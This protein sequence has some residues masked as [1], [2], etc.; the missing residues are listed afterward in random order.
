MFTRVTGRSGPHGILSGSWRHGPATSILLLASVVAAAALAVALPHTNVTANA[1]SASLVSNCLAE[2]STL[3]ESGELL[4]T[5]DVEG[6]RLDLHSPVDS[7]GEVRLNGLHVE[8]LGLLGRLVQAEGK[9]EVTFVA[10]RQVGKDEVSSLSWSVEVGHARCRDTSQDGGI[11]GSSILDA[12]VSH[13]ASLLQTG[14]EEEIGVVVEGNVL[15]L[16][17]GGTLN[18]TKFNNR[19]RVNRSSVAVSCEGVSTRRIPKRQTAMRH[20]YICRVENAPFMPEP[21]ARARSG[22]CRTVNWYHRCRFSLVTRWMRWTMSREAEEATE[23]GVAMMPR[24]IA[25]VEYDCK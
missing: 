6:L 10:D 7:G 9:T 13:G 20:C 14:I 15:A 25:V 23:V 18:D 5:E 17:D 1:N 21:H 11:V 3:H 22:C 16:L 19:R 4:G 2:R 24:E 12:A 8:I